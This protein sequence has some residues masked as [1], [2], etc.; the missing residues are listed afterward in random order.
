[1]K[2]AGFQSPEGD[3][4]HCHEVWAERARYELPR[5]VSI[6]RRGFSSLSHAFVDAMW[7]RVDEVSIPRRGF[8]SLSPSCSDPVVQRGR[9][10]VSIPRRGFSSLSRQK[11]QCCHSGIHASF[12]PPKGILFIVTRGRSG[13]SR[14]SS[15]ACV[16]QSPE[17]DSLH[18]HLQDIWLSAIILGVSIPRR[19]FSS[20][21]RTLTAWVD[22]SNCI[23]VSIPRRG[24]S[25]LSQLEVKMKDWMK[26]VFQSPKGILFIVT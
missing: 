15:T 14:S 21:S 25:S 9:I 3:S 24:F 23:K 20:L 1:M 11:W 26:F 13:R 22:V 10:L 8:S 6:P 18:C 17:G 16:F 19:G 7:N 12:N 2:E 5:I 4:L